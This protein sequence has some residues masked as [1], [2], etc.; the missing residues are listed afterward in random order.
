[1]MRPCALAQGSLLC[2]TFDSVFQSPAVQNPRE[3]SR[4]RNGDTTAG[5]GFFM[6]LRFGVAADS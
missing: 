4:D 3:T 2:Y 6:R 1:M 5:C